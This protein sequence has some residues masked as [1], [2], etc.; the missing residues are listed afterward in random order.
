M[1]VWIFLQMRRV[2]SL[3][4]VVVSLRFRVEQYW[5]LSVTSSH[6]LRNNLIEFLDDHFLIP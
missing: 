6:Q 1:W 2:Y 3:H 5:Y 4:V